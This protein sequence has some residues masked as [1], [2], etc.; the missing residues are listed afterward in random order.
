MSGPAPAVLL[1]EDRDLTEI[2]ISN[3]VPIVFLP[4]YA[5]FANMA[6]DARCEAA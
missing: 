5:R 4:Q 2:I 1:P 6:A 3:V